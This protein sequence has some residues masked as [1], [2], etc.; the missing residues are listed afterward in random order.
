MTCDI[1]ACARHWADR[2]TRRP[3]VNGTAD[4]A[5]FGPWFAEALRD[6]AD[7]GPDAQ[8]WTIPVAPGDGRHCVA[9]FIRGSGRRTVLL[10]GHYDTVTTEDY[11]DL[12]DAAIRPDDLLQALRETL[13][14]RAE[15]PAERLARQDFAGDDYLPGRGLLDMKAG[16][17]AGLAAMRDFAMAA[18][19]SGNILFIAVPDEENASAGA[20]RAAREIAAIAGRLEIDIAAAINLDAIADDGDGSAG[21]TIALGTVGKVLPTAFVVGVPTHAGFPLNGINAAALAAAI[22]ARLEWA[23]ELT[24]C[25]AAQPGT[26]PSLLSLRDGKAGYDVTTPATAF[27]TWN[28]LIHKRSPQQ[29]LDSF[30]ELCAETATQFRDD[31]LRRARASAHSG[32]PLPEPAAIRLY[33]YE[34]V[35]AEAER[36]S[37]GLSRALSDFSAELAQ[38]RLALPEQCHRLTER[39]WRE[40]R[41]AGPAIV[42]GFGSVPYLPT[43]LSG[44]ADARALEA[45]ARAAAQASEGRYGSRIGCS[46]YFAGISDMSFFGEADE[47]ALEIVARNTPVWGTGIAWPE[48]P[49]LGNIPIVN[50][51]PWGRDYHTPLERLHVGYAFDVLPRL[52]SDLVGDVLNRDMPAPG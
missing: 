27:A 33:R 35:L 16:L 52:L 15:T 19:R 29:V 44:S 50:A 28:V 11:A 6:S 5:S 9:L 42:T 1:A 47:A 39:V 18:D 22:A 2:L 36:Q 3:S 45:A 43:G 7:F 34:D 26:P 4:E 38:S 14:T 10:T 24:D 13:S 46:D 51:G 49:A 12:Q 23:T 40:S 20:R 48:G 32:V 31:L 37:P 30:D 25:T 21:R 17:A 41:Y 8:V